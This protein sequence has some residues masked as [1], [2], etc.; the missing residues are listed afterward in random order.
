MSEEAVL[1]EKIKE[2]SKEDIKKML[3]VSVKYDSY[4]A[5]CFAMLLLENE[6]S[7]MLNS[8]DNII[9]EEFVDLLSIIDKKKAIELIKIKF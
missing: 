3:I 1:T 6:E 4:S 9:L 8:E 7:T 2:L 5:K